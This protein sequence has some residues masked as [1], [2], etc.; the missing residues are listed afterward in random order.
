MYLLGNAPQ[1]VL[2]GPNSLWEAVMQEAFVG[3]WARQPHF[4]VETLGTLHDLNHRF[5]DLIGAP[6]VESPAT[7]R[8][9]LPGEVA[10]QFAPLSAAQRRSGPA[11]PA[12]AARPPVRP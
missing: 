8:S 7:G 12:K 1:T 4:S 2:R 5:L 10:A 3:G 11:R 9:K 6:P